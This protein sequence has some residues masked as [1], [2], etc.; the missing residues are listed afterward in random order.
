MSTVMVSLSKFGLAEAIRD[1]CRQQ[2]GREP[3]PLR[4]QLN[5][6]LIIRRATYESIASAKADEADNI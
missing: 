6:A 5:G 2:T 3:L 4:R 1:V